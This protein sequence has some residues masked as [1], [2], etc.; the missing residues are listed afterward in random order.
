MSALALP[1]NA[2]ILV[3]VLRRLGDVL[4]TTPLIRSLRRAWPNACIDALV[5][6]DTAGIVAG[7][8]DLT[9]V[10]SMPVRP[11]AAESLKVAARLWRQY[12]LAI[13]T[14]CGDRPTFFAIIAGRIRVAPVEATVN[15]WLKRCFLNRSVRHEAGVHRVEEILRLAEVIAV[16]RVPKVVCPRPRTAENLPAGD[17][18]VIHA[19]PMFRY[20]QWT[21]HG[22]R[23]LAAA[24]VARGLAVVA[25]GGP[26]KSECAYLDERRGFVGAPRRW[27][28]WL[29]RTC[30]TAG[31]GPHLCRARYLG[32][33]SCRG[34]GLP[35]RRALWADRS[36]LVGTLAG[37]RA[38]G[39]LGGGCNDPAARQYLAGAEPAALRAVPTGGV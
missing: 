39:A 27:P 24:L 21:R 11:T 9:G 38:R 12:D 14:Q 13:S 19:A 3:V 26:A 25:T 18:A 29:V 15:G 28:T 37:G 1:S 22:W 4:L 20:K 6:D 23:A 17:Y 7:N 5:F 32:D 16:A 33:P 36:A 30:G 35:D 34:R 8:P 2:K 10:V 31:K